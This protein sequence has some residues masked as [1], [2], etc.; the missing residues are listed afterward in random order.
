M[1]NSS[2]NFEENKE[3]NLVIIDKTKV[4]ARKALLI[5]I[6][7]TGTS[8]ELNGCI[9]D[10]HN[11]KNMLI[12]NKY[13]AENDIT[14]MNDTSSGQN[15]PTKENMLKAFNELV[16]FSNK[17]ADKDVYLF[18]SYS[19]HG[20]Y[21]I[22]TSGD[23]LDGKD[24]V[25]CPIDCDTVGFIVDDELRNNFI[26][27]LH[28][29]VKLVFL[30]DSCHSGSAIDLKYNYKF[31][32]IQTCI[33]DRKYKDTVCQVVFISGCTDNQTSADAYLPDINNGNKF[34]YQGA[35]TASFLKVFK[36]EITYTELIKQM[37][38]FLRTNRFTQIPQLSAGKAIN[39]KEPFLISLYNNQ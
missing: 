21:Q 6:N 22:D 12:K 28:S 31:D 10:S 36:D 18:V 32:I 29:R 20:Y 16:E 1:G 8:N 37:R 15:Y 11:L 9:N 33:V 25:F 2:S 34:V 3:E 26:N 19:G 24:E 39:I 13:F 5:G 14:L 30:C 35:M 7:Y 38:Q 23:E 27:K 4:I 17:N